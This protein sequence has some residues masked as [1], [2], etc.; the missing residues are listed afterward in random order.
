MEDQTLPTVRDMYNATRENFDYNVIRAY[1]GKHKLLGVNAKPTKKDHFL[2]LV[3]KLNSSPGPASNS[4]FTQ[5][6]PT[7]R[8]S[9][10]KRPSLR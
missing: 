6:Q 8:F 3:V 10:P 1:E 7:S 5:A 2:D 4:Y 9:G